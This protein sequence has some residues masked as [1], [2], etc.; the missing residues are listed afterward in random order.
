MTTVQEE[1]RAVVGY[2]GIYEVSS[3]GRVKRVAAG[4]G[5]KRLGQPMRV[6]VGANGYA[7][8]RLNNQ[9]GKSHYVHALVAT[10]FLG[11]CPDSHEVHH[12]DANRA[13]NRVEN[14]AY[15]TRSGNMRACVGMGRHRS[16]R[17]S[18]NPFAKLTECDVKEIRRLHPGV[19]GP[20]LAARYG[21]NT[22]T[23]YR[24][25]SR[26]KWSHVR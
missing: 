9:G 1:W 18:R 12:R 23:I 11:P 3:F 13:N 4:Q 8:I 16:V 19:S 17:G 25:L 5:V 20:K 10:S 24:I 6:H 2:E 7:K 26:K 21:V 14:L 22:T 15:V